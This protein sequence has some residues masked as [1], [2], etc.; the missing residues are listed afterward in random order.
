MLV[1]VYKECHDPH[2]FILVLPE[3][4]LEAL[5]ERA[6][7]ALNGVRYLADVALDPD[8]DKLAF[9]VS[10]AIHDLL[11]QGFHISEGILGTKLHCST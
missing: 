3:F 11:G 10:N 1:E 7:K 2:R 4:G 5:P 8:K 9:G 6:L